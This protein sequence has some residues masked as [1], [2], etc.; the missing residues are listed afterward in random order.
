MI[1]VRLPDGASAAPQT[2]AEQSLM[3]SPS[4]SIAC[5]PSTK[6][7]ASFPRFPWTGDMV[8]SNPPPHS[9]ESP[10]ETDRAPFA[11]SKE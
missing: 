8:Q 1:Q 7:T 4:P 3:P 10:P 2:P 6:L 5:V 9:A 11:S